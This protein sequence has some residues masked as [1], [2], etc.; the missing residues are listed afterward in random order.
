[1]PSARA[2]SHWPRSTETMPPRN[3]SAKKAADWIENVSTAATYGV[4][5]TPIRIGSAKKNQNSCTS[6]GVVRKTSITAP[7]GHA[8]PARC[9]ESR[10]SAST[11]PSGTPKA[12]AAPVTFSVLRRPSASRSAFAHTGAKF[13]RAWQGRSASAATTCR[14]FPS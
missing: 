14:A 13:Q 11:R 5:S 2:A 10:I 7:A 1:M 9:G 3:T 6:G 8:Q 4:I 12:S